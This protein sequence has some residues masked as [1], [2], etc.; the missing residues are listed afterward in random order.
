MCLCDTMNTYHPRYSGMY[1]C[2]VW[3]GGLM[4]EGIQE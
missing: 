3:T 2:E 1:V 4:L